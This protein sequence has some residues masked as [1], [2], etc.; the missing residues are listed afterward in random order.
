M[1]TEAGHQWTDAVQTGALHIGL[2]QRQCACG[3]MCTLT[4]TC[5]ECEKKKML[6]H[7]LQTKLQINEPG[8]KYEREA[9]HVAAQVMRMPDGRSGGAQSRWSSPVIQR[10]VGG[11]GGQAGNE[12]SLQRAEAAG[13]AS[14]P[15]GEQPA[16]EGA[17]PK[18]GSSD[19]GGSRCPSWRNDPESISKRAAETYVQHD[20]TP[21]SQATVQKIRCEPPISNGNYGCFVHFSDGLVVRV[22]VRATDIV[23]GMGPGQIATE[24]PP[25]A[26]PLCFYDYHCPDGFLVL[27]KR[28][29]RSAKASAPGGSAAPPAVAQR[30]VAP[31]TSPSDGSLSSVQHVLASPGR[32]LDASTREFFAARFGH[33]FGEVRI[34]DDATAAASARGVRALAYT[35]GKDVVFGAGQYSP[36]TKSGR[37][38]LAHELTHVI[39]QRGG[40][41]L[42]IQRHK[43]DV[44]GYTGGQSGRVIVL[45]AGNPT[46]VAPAV[47]GHPGH[48]E[49][50]PSVGPIPTGL[51]AMQPGVTRP[52]VAAIQSGVCGANAIASGYQE[53]TSTDPSP[54]SG[55]HYCNV[56]C[57]TADNPAQQCY[58]PQDCWGPKRIKIQGSKTITT[59]EGVRKRRDGFY[60]HGG[61]P[62]DAV[63]SGCVKTLDNGVF[64]EIRKL[65]GVKGTVPFC[66]GTACPK[67]LEVKGTMLQM[68]E[69]AIRAV[70]MGNGMMLP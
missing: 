56:P 28:E 6:G 67:D 62:Q 63:S 32:P 43:D 54:C 34:H 60:L 24:T 68:T 23:V 27:T 48:G 55:A 69:A 9:E 35:V 29:C 3:G 20:I 33:D 25:A 46:Y 42:N 30:K 11:S 50:E 17:A 31:E 44:V 37:H 13:E 52:A 22:I 15:V 21:T 16:S 5:S 51:Y 58:T 40:S 64:S 1:R 26:T 38:L 2:L 65:T 4:G 53:I 12:G 66:V 7:S 49:N 59:P 14:A 70:A 47:S 10:L 61:N 18:D 36:G 39:Q 19:E 57:P 45:N 8:D 41:A